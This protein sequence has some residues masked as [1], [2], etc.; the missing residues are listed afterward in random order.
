M[1]PKVERDLE[2]ILALL[3]LGSIISAPARHSDTDVPALWNPGC[4]LSGRGRNSRNLGEKLMKT[5]VLYLTACCGAGLFLAGPAAAQNTSRFSFNA[6]AGF[7]EPVKQ[8]DGRFNTGFNINA[9]V[10]INLHPRLGLMAEFGFND[11]G[12]SDRSLTNAGVPGGN[13]RIYSATLN[14][15]FHFNPRGRFDVYAIGGGGFYRRTID[16]TAPGVGSDV[17]FDPFYGVF[18]PA[19]VPVTNVLASFTQ[20]KG[21]L[22]I[23]GGFSVRVKGDSNAKFYAETRYHYIFTTPVRTTVLPVTFGF[24]W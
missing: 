7:T 3:L 15:I 16:Y 8:A 11:L 10:G 20:N 6:G 13:G 24:R 17:F 1:R 9:G 21:G 5:K 14:P 23:G 18:Y 12:L 4:N 19:A 22:N 2:C